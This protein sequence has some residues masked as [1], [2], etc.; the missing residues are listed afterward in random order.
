MWVLVIDSSGNFQLYNSTDG[1]SWTARGSAL[2]RANVIESSNIFI[3]NSGYLHW[4]Y[5]TNESSQDRIYYRRF[6]TNNTAYTW[7]AELLVASAGNGGVAGT[8]FTGISQKA[9]LYNAPSFSN[10]HCL[11]ATGYIDGVGNNGV[12]LHV[13]QGNTNDTTKSVNNSAISGRRWW[14]SPGSG[15]NTP[16]VDIR[17]GGDAKSVDPSAFI[18]WG[19]NTTWLVRVPTVGSSYNYWITPTDATRIWDH[20]LNTDFTAGRFT[21]TSN[22]DVFLMP[23]QN[24]NSPTTVTVL[25][26]N[27]ANTFTDSIVTPAHPQG[28]ITSSQVNY[29][30]SII[31]VFAIG[32]ANNVLYFIDYDTSNGTWTSWGTVD[33]TAC[34]TSTDWGVRESVFGCT[35]KHDVYMMQGSGPSTLKSFHLSAFSKPPNAPTWAAPSSGLAQDVNATLTLD[36]DFSDLDPSDTQ[37]AYALSRQIGA[38]ALQYYTAAGGTWGSTEVQN[39]SAASAVTLASGWGADSDAN[40]VYKVKTWDS[41]SLAGVYSNG[42]VVVPSAKDNPTLTAPG[43]SIASKQVTASWTVATQTAFKIQLSGDVTYDTGWIVSTS[44]SYTVPKD[45][46][47]GNSVTLTL[48]TQNDEGLTSN[49]VSQAFTVAFTPPAVPT[50]VATPNNTTGLI[51]IAITNPTGGVSTFVGAGAAVKANNASLTPVAHASSARQDLMILFASIRNSGTG[52]VNLPTG[53]TSLVN[54]GN[55]R[56]MGRFFTDGTGSD[57]PTVTFTGGATGADTIAQIATFRGAGMNSLGTVLSATVLNGAAQNIA[58]PSLAIAVNN[59][60]VLVL[61]WKQDG[62]GT[63]IATLA[64]MTEIGETESALGSGS[65]Q[66]W[67]Y[68]IQTTGT[69]ITGSSFTVTGG[70]SQISRGITMAL[71][72]KPALAYNDIYRRIVGNT[73]VTLDNGT[74]GIRIATQLPSGSTYNDFTAKSG[75]AYEYQ[76]VALGVN[77]TSAFS[78]WTA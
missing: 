42:L 7:E 52:T 8:Y 58:Y 39:T 74:S 38:G 18:T 30:W 25:R 64:G 34:T 72:V 20:N 70:T 36:W 46:A 6:N 48:Y 23:M 76:I 67:D 61:G 53:W 54:F 50:L 43:A 71:D 29:A 77:G 19:R 11:I 1:S 75:V 45:M 2:V 9:I 12:M 4:V 65:E 33:A 13:V 57:D 68:V 41:T 27:D 21:G 3:D 40:H 24:V 14:Y 63:G 22:Q 78:A 69:N 37:S 60:T 35:W 51:G 59:Q 47:D 56:V 55:T 62:A 66:V 16:S 5:R 28:N 73:D 44:T 26:R 17:H 32:T 10:Y 49:A 31:R 15:R